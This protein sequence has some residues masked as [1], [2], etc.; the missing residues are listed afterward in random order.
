MRKSLFILSIF[1]MSAWTYSQSAESKK[2]IAVEGD[3]LYSISKKYHTSVAKLIE[4]N[5][6]VDESGVK[7]GM[8]LVLP[9]E[10]PVTEKKTQQEPVKSDP[11]PVQ[12]KESQEPKYFPPTVVPDENISEEPKEQASSVTV[13]EH[14]VAEGETYYSLSKKYKTTVSEL[15]ALNGDAPLKAGTKIIVSKKETSTSPSTEKKAHES[16]LFEEP[17][18]PEAVPADKTEVKVEKPAEPIAVTEEKKTPV[19]PSPEV[20]VEKHENKTVLKTVSDTK[21]P[22]VEPVAYNNAVKRILI[23][24]FDPY[25]YFSDA[26]MEIA[27]QSKLEHTKIRQAFRRRLNALL[28]PQGYETVHLL[29]GRIKDS[30]TDL[31]RVY[32]NVSYNYQDALYNP[33]AQMQRV[34]TTQGQLKEAD[35]THVVKETNDPLGNSRASLAKDEGKYYGVKISDPNF[36]PYFNSKYKIDYYIFVNQFEVKT[37]YATCLDRTTKNYERNF[38]THF[39][40]FDNTGKQIAG[41]RIKI[42]Y[43]SNENNIQKILTDNMQKVATQIIGE[44]PSAQ[45]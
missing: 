9:G 11:A 21:I 10:S 44:L 1:V 32:K 3:N 45:K 28:E 26:D 5:P 12:T 19:E 35:K 31:N 24:P 16:V 13:E 33:N 25:L 37:N 14:L 23:I 17:P 6:Q 40:I 4:L 43:E 36:F 34:Q 18:K 27:K 2:Y 30:L 7:P 8:E 38:I 20:K 39:S 15:K 42:Y 29:G 22:V 41:N